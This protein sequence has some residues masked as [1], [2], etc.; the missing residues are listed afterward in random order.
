LYEAN[1]KA[2]FQIV[3]NRNALKWK[4]I[5]WLGCTLLGAA[6]GLVSIGLNYLLELVTGFKK[7]PGESWIIFIGFLLFGV[8]SGFVG[9]AKMRPKIWD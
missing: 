7:V 1:I 2:A 5:A 4:L 9:A 3:M 8:I 6:T